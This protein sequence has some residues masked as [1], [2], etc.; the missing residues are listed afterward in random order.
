MTQM[1]SELSVLKD[2]IKELIGVLRKQ[3]FLTYFKKVSILEHTT[4]TIV[5][6]VVSS[7]MR[8]NLSHKFYDEIKAATVKICPTITAIDF[9]IDKN[10]DNPSHAGVVD[11]PTFYKEATNKKKRDDTHGAEVV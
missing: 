5:F 1:D 3:D 7:F 8:D 9:R 6:G 11:C 2:I 10:I 4:D